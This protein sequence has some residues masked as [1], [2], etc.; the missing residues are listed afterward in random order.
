MQKSLKLIA[1]ALLAAALAGCGEDPAKSPE[2]T[3]MIG[4]EYITKALLLVRHDGP[5]GISTDIPGEGGAASLEEIIA[6]TREG[7]P[8]ALLPAGSRFRVEDVYST[9]GTASGTVLRFKLR[10]LAPEEYRNLEL[11]YVGLIDYNRHPRT[12]KAD[13]IEEAPAQ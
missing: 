2:Y 9:W 11:S 1:S 12:F 13:L 6:L 10:V 3:A 8:P 4:K 7:K 5:M